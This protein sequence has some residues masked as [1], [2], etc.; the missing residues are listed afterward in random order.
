[1]DFR[2][3]KKKEIN[4]TKSYIIYTAEWWKPDNSKNAFNIHGNFCDI[5]STKSIGGEKVR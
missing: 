4:E 5:L 3:G 1:M 2:P